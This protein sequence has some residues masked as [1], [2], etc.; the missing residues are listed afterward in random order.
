M[1]INTPNTLFSLKNYTVFCVPSKLIRNILNEIG[2]SR[3]ITFRLV[4]EG[5]NR[6]I[7]VDSKSDLQVKN[8]K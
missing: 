8:K 1:E 6:S 4:G 5:T 3:E 7:D 2:R